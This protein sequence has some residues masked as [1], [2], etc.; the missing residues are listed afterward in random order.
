[1]LTTLTE[2]QVVDFEGEPHVVVKDLPRRQLVLKPISEEYGW[3]DIF[4]SRHGDKVFIAQF[5]YGLGNY[6]SLTTGNRHRE[7]DQ[8]SKVEVVQTLLRKGYTK[9]GHLRD[10]GKP[11]S[12]Q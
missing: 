9:V 12:I 11:L 4:E 3:G 10:L 7:G 1:M 6:F 8:G 5:A 2:N